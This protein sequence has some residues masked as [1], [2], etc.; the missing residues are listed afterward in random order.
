MKSFGS[1]SSLFSSENQVPET[2]ND[3]QNYSFNF[4]SHYATW[5]YDVEYQ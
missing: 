2:I 3:L 1:C 5:C 4:N